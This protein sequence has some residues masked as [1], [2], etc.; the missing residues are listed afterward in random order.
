VEFR[1]TDVETVTAYGKYFLSAHYYTSGVRSEWQVRFRP[2]DDVRS[3]PV[4]PPSDDPDVEADA[5][6]SLEAAKAACEQHHAHL[7]GLKALAVQA[8]VVR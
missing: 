3:V 4:E 5:W 2:I 1:I 7:A 6:P 8:E